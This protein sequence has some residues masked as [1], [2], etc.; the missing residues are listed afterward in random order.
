M[1][2]S[3]QQGTIVFRQYRSQKGVNET[4]ESFSSLNELFELCLQSDNPKLVDR[5][6]IEGIADDGNKH[7]LTLVFQSVTIEKN[8]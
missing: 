1:T 4:T 3:V 6:H 7:I 5:V 2:S 8:V